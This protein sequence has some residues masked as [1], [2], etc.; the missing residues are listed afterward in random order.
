F[1]IR[2]RRARLAPDRVSMQRRI[3]P[4][5]DGQPLLARN[6]FHD[7]LAQQTLGVLH[8]QEH[9]AHAVGSGLRQRES[10]F[11]ALAHEELMRDLDQNAGSV[12]GLRVAPAS[13]AMR[14][15]DKDLNAFLHDLV[16]FVAIQIHYEAHTAGVVFMTGV[17]QSLLLRRVSHNSEYLR[18]HYRVNRIYWLVI[19]ARVML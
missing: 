3:A 4:A 16:R 1:N 2:L 14:Q 19:L 11:G 8:R 17:I 13:A 10:Q 15:I 5:E 12:A 9:H 6:A 7:S 18:A